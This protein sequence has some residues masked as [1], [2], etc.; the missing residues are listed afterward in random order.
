MNLFVYYLTNPSTQLI[1]VGITVIRVGI[2]ILMIGHGLPKLYAG[3]QTWQQIGT[4]MQ[5]LGIYFWPTFWGLLAALTELLGGISFV[6]GIAT[7]FWAFMLAGMMTIA[8]IYHVHKND[9]FAVTSHALALLIVFIGFMIMGSGMFSLDYYF[10]LR[11]MGNP[12]R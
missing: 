1:Q 6:F 2:G 10:F 7:R 5:N 8:Y 12:V 11:N 9:P 4:A 3:A